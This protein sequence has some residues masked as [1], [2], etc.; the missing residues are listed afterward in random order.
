MKAI[1]TT[2]PSCATSD[3]DIGMNFARAAARAVSRMP[4]RVLRKMAGP[5]IEIDGNTLDLQIQVFA[6]AAKRGGK[7]DVTPEGMRRGF[8]ELVSIASS[9]PVGDVAIHDR[10]IPGPAAQ[11]P[12]RVYHPAAASGA[13]P[14]IVWHHQGGGVIGDLD[15]DHWLCTE[16]ARGCGAVVVSIGYRL[17]PEHK[18]PAAVDDSLRSYQ[19][20][21]DNA[22]GLG[23][24]PGRVAVG[25]TSTGAT[26]AAVV[27][28]E[29]RRQ[30]VPQPALQ[31]LAYGDLDGTLVGGSRESCADCFPLTT[32]TLA[33]FA[34]NYLPEMSALDDHRVSPGRSDELW[35]LARAVVTTAGFDPLRDAGDAYAKSLAAAGVS[36]T[37]RC[38][39]SLPHSFTIMGGISKEARRATG[40]LVQDVAGGFAT[41]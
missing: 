11:L 6:A 32:D 39:A 36:V 27:C 40:R 9:D 41:D 23:I 2:S 18:F 13:A 8:A 17:A 16:L 3:P 29:R 5:P 15:T 1:P 4:R 14:A 25:G 20:V 24:D 35:G 38:E 19:W 7:I 21:L 10:M 22:A 30:G 37:H 12:V 28:Q 33:F 34:A 31:V 26:L